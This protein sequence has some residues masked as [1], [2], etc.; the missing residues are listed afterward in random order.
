MTKNN[1]TYAVSF[2]FLIIGIVHALRLFNA[3]EAQIGDFTV[4]IWA[5]WV[6]VLVAFYLSFQGFK[7]A[8]K[9]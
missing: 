8:K 5:S 9:A 2:L 6:A 4:P 7:L 3:W 1:F